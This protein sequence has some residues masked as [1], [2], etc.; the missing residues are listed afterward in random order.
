MMDAC[1]RAA[2]G[3]EGRRSGDSVRELEVEEFQSLGVRLVLV[4]TNKVRWSEPRH[5]RCYNRNRFPV[6][7]LMKQFWGAT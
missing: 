6:R 2:E 7:K 5:L 1:R 3:G 4:A